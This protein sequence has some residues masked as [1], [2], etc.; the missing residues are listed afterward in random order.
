MLCMPIKLS[1]GHTVRPFRHL[2]T[3]YQS[4]I[5]KIG[6]TWLLK[7]ASVCR[8]WKR[9]RTDP[10]LYAAKFKHLRDVQSTQHAKPNLIRWVLLGIRSS[11]F[12][13]KMMMR[14]SSNERST[15]AMLWSAVWTENVVHHQ[16][17]KIIRSKKK[18]KKKRIRRPAPHW[19]IYFSI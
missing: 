19:Q 10:D 2:A 14:G 3:K 4:S 6:Q 15:D 9:R 1:E 16:A 7:M 8:W 18:R 5:M 13:I 12:C 11:A 17:Q